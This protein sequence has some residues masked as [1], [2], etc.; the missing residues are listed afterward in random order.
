MTK[1]AVAGRTRRLLSMV[2]RKAKQ[3]GVPDTE[4][5]VTPDLLEEAEHYGDICRRIVWSSCDSCCSTVV[6]SCSSRTKFA[7]AL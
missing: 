7:K 4:S 1:D 3:D 2:D 6:S 5:A